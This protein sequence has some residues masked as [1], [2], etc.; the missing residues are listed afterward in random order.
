MMTNDTQ[1]PPDFVARMR[2]WLGDEADA[3]LAALTK[4]DYGI[5]LNPRRGTPAALA[6]ILPWRTQP[7]PWCPEGR[8][9][10]PSGDEQHA[11]L[12]DTSLGAHP[13]HMAGVYYIQ[14]PTAMA[15]AALLDA[16]PGE[17]VLDLAASPGSK[18]TH[19]ASRMGGEGVLVANEIARRRTTV[20]AMNLER[21]GVTNAL[22]TNAY[23]E[24][25]SEVWAGLFD[26][27][28]VDAPCSG[29]GT[30]SRDARALADWSLK[31]VRGYAARQREILSQAAPLV[32]AGGRILYGTC[33]FSPEEN[34]SVIAAFL[35]AHPDFELAK[36]P[37]LPGMRPGHPEW[38]GAPEALRTTGRFWPHTGPGHGHFYALLRRKGT[39]PDDLPAQWTG[40]DVPGRVLRLYEQTLGDVLTGPLPQ[41]GLILTE[42]DDCYI[43]PMAPALWAKVPV[44]RPGWW[45]AS[46]RHGKIT[47]DHALAMALKPAAVTDHVDLAPDDP[48]LSRY[49]DGSV[50]SEDGPR[51]KG[52]AGGFVLI[53]VDGFP[54]GWAKRADGR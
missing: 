14:D 53:T 48:R 12:E 6:E 26:A 49:L 19:I 8:W 20:L 3:F 31:T 32:R 39:P 37:A 44:L 40:Q 43:T 33:T 54:V 9:L 30:F 7:V 15:A 45:V 35:E 22:V 24:R 23:P 16:Q 1:W 34:E 10:D 47:P 25:L 42:D 27:M 13:Y 50:W 11:D 17:W 46:L 5:R 51:R 2:T 21:M 38:V 52:R 29:E 41:E 18:A 4:R 36:L 28:L